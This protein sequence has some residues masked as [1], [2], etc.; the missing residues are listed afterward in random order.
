MSARAVASV[1]T[2]CPV[3]GDAEGTLGVFKLFAEFVI[4]LLDLIGATATIS[5]TAPTT[6][7]SQTVPAA[8]GIAAADCAPTIAV[9]VAR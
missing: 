5:P 9:A 8:P 6:S 1:Q 3:S 4:L 7:P 2:V